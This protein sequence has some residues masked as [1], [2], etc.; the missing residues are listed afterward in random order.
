MLF[1]YV[2]YYLLIGLTFNLIYDILIDYIKTKG[3]T[4]ENRFTM[5]E[6]IFVALIWPIYS[7]LFIVNFFKLLVK[8]NKND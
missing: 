7:S 5:T 6:R 4:D 2:F 1:K 8:K 3:K